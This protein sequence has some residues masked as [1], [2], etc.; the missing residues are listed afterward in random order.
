VRLLIVRIGAIGDVVMALAAVEAARSLERDT[1][2][3]WL[4]GE[5]V[6]PLLEQVGTVDEIVAVDDRALLK[7][8]ARERTREIGKAW[9]ALAGR[10]FDLVVTLHADPRYRVLTAVV[11][12]A[13]RRSL[14]SSGGRPAPIPGRYE[15]DEYARL[16]HG[17]DGP[18]APPA[19]LPRMSFPPAGHL[20]PADGPTVMIAPGGAK[21]VLRDDGLRRWPLESYAQV[22]AELIARGLHV[23]L[24]GGPGDDWVRA[25]FAELAVIDLVGRTDLIEL[26]GTIQACDLL[27]THDSGPMHLAFLARTP[28]IA[29]FGPT[30]PTERLPH[31]ARVRALWGGGHLACRPCYD[32]RDYAPCPNNVCIQS[33]APAEVVAETMQMLA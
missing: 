25:A 15:G 9:R 12:G 4:C 33:V 19:R 10:R 6:R 29:L 1:R 22:A 21:N 20:L 11:R 7:G 2:V 13:T 16:V 31:D 5:L 23:V 3:T 18:D 28:T 17:I 14:R 26:G 32:G 8:T 24:T 27:I 30:R